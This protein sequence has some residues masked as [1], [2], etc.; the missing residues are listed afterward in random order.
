MRQCIDTSCL[1][2]RSSVSA[3]DHGIDDGF[4]GGI[5]RSKKQ[6]D[7]CNH[8]GPIFA[9]LPLLSPDSPYWLAVEN[10]RKISPL[11]FPP[12]RACAG[13]AERGAFGE[14]LELVGEQG[15]VGGE[16]DDQR[17]LIL[18]EW[19]LTAGPMVHL[20]FQMCAYG[21]ARDGKLISAVR[22]W[23]APARRPS[24]RRVFREACVRM[25][26]SRL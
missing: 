24:S 7:R 17:A 26:R 13:H 18:L 4:L 21:Y 1:C 23:T 6:T 19:I 11:P 2:V 3:G 9:H 8:S 20:F 12:R 10:A 14:P 22:N 15:R 25:S 5:G 16:D